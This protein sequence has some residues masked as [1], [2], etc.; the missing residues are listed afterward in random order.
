MGRMGMALANMPIL[1]ISRHKEV[2]NIAGRPL[3]RDL[4]STASKTRFC[5]VRSA[6]NTETYHLHLAQNNLGQNETPPF[7]YYYTLDGPWAALRNALIAAQHGAANSRRRAGC[8]P[9]KE[10]LSRFA[11]APNGNA[12]AVMAY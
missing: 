11:A 2:R 12:V 4:D 10:P 6:V 7:S 5:H 1:Y 8:P 3:P 9:N